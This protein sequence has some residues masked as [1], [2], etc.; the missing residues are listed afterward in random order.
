M[1]DD[2]CFKQLPSPKFNFNSRNS[3]SHFFSLQIPS[4]PF[5]FNQLKTKKLGN[6]GK[7]KKVNIFSWLPLIINFTSKQ[8]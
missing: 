3:N 6:S 1:A 2:E 8:K 7:L 4:P 5:I